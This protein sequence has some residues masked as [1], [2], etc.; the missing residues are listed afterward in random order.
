MLGALVCLGEER[1]L[2]REVGVGKWKQEIRREYR[3][4]WD[5]KGK[6]SFLRK[7]EE[8]VAWL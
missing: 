6:E 2:G 7:I 4:R 3:S 5:S 8:A 1:L